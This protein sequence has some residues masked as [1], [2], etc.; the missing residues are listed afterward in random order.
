M[1]QG[2]FQD[3]SMLPRSK[4]TA[5]DD[6]SEEKILKHAQEVISDP[7]IQWRQITGQED[8]LC[9]PLKYIAD[10]EV[11]GKKIRVVFEPDNRGI[12]AAYFEK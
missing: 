2:K 12:L 1:L 8:F 10:T 9:R 6:W 7:Q 5:L 4:N 11:E 3:Q